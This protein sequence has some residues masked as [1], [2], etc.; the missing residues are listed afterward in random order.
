MQLQSIILVLVLVMIL[1]ASVFVR[2]D[3][4]IFLDGMNSQSGLIQRLGLDNLN[5]SQVNNS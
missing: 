1:V 2:N 3:E 4:G 5:R